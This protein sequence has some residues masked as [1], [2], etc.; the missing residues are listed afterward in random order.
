LESGA[1]GRQ[2]GSEGENF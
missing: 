1:T 2:E